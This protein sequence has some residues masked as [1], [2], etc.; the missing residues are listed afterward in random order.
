MTARRNGKPKTE[1]ERKSRHTRLHPGTKMPARRG[2]RNR[3]A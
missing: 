1:A 3:N 2:R